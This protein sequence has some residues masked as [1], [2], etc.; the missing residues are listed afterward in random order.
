MQF[1]IL[2]VA[3]CIAAVATAQANELFCQARAIAS[4]TTCLLGNKECNSLERLSS[5]VC[6]HTGSKPEI[7]QCL[8]ALLQDPHFIGTLKPDD[9]TSEI[10]APAV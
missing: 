5:C 3:A 2:A 9:I 10:A 4:T 7:R 8:K 1:K 6:Y